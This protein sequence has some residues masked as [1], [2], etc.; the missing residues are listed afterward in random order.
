M[1]INL[2]YFAVKPLGHLLIYEMKDRNIRHA[3]Q[4]FCMS[5]DLHAFSTS[6][7]QELPALHEAN[8]CYFTISKYHDSPP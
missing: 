4:M 8:R 5:R 7:P 1:I 6:L 3:N 2:I